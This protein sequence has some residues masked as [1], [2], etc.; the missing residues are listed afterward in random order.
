M[1]A[2]FYAVVNILNDFNKIVKE[3]SFYLLLLRYFSSF[4]VSFDPYILDEGLAGQLNKI[5]T[6]FK[7]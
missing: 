1:E 4:R 7:L 6:F 2:V 3:T 5:F